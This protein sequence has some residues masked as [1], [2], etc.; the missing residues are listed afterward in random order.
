MKK[1]TF[2]VALLAVLGLMLTSSAMAATQ[3]GTF[4]KVALCDKGDDGDGSSNVAWC[5]DDDDSRVVLGDDCDGDGD[6]DSERAAWCG[7]DD[8]SRV[9]LGDDCDGDGDDSEG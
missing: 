9:V 6:G 2:L 3:A 7:D 8:D 1:T 5:G 4:G